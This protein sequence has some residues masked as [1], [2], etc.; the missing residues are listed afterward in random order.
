MNVFHW[1]IVDDQSFPYESKKYPNLSKQGAYHPTMVY[2]QKDVQAVINFAR[3]LGI[4]V[5]PE[6]D[7]PGHTRSWGNSIPALLTECY[8]KS[9][10]TGMLGPMNPT[11]E[12]TYEFLKEFFEEVIEVFPDSYLHIG[13][14]EVE[15]DCW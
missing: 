3:L 8:E 10:P 4:R 13:G 11:R 2:T 15:K 5:I 9:K 14:D 12:T 6:F 1:H 7:T